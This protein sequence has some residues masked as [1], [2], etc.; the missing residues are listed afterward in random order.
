MSGLFGISEA[1]AEEPEIDAVTSASKNLVEN[2]RNIKK[3]FVIFLRKR[4]TK[5]AKSYNIRP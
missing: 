2:R 4:L 3:L 1:R 5:H